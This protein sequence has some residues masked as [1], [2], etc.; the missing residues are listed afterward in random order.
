MGHRKNRSASRHTVSSHRACQLF[1]H[2]AD[3][4]GD[5]RMSLENAPGASFMVWGDAWSHDRRIV[6]KTRRTPTA[7]TGNGPQRH[8]SLARRRGADPPVRGSRTR[9]RVRATGSRSAGSGPIPCRGRA[10]VPWL[11]SGCDSRVRLTWPRR[12]PSIQLPTGNGSCLGLR[13]CHWGMDRIVGIAHHEQRRSAWQL[14]WCGRHFSVP[15]LARWSLLLALCSGSFSM[16]RLQ[17]SNE[18]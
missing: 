8:R 2:S 3:Y 11:A 7:T 18:Q 5:V 14:S 1:P 13:P 9:K 12:D 6:N 17:R 15:Q 16:W 10:S 4:S